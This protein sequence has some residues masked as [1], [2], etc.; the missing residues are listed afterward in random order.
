[1]SAKESGTLTT[2]YYRFQEIGE[3]W[4]FITSCG[5]SFK[6]YKKEKEPMTKATITDLPENMGRPYFPEHTEVEKDTE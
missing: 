2:V 3:F 4:I 1:M 5:S 6:A